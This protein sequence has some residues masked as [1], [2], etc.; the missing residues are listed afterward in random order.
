[1]MK[2]K[3]LSNTDAELLERNVNDFIEDHPTIIDIKYQTVL[4][5]GIVVNDRVLILYNDEDNEKEV[6]NDE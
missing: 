3:I 2:V 6:S 4:I 1:M 5:S